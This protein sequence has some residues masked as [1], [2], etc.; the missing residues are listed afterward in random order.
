MFDRL[1]S[2]VALYSVIGVA[3]VLVGV[4][5]VTAGSPEIVCSLGS[6]DSLV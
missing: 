6:G 2:A 1:V 5:F 3:I 4:S